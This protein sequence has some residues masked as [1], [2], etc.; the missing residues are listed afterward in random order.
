MLTL[1]VGPVRRVFAWGN[2]PATWKVVQI[3]GLFLMVGGFVRR[4]RA[5]FPLGDYMSVPV[6]ARGL[7]MRELYSRIGNPICVYRA[8]VIA[9]LI[10][11]FAAVL[12]RLAAAFAGSGFCDPYSAAAGVRAEGI[13]GS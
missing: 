2:L 13:S 7:I 12:R 4:A 10:S 8:T 1:I 3:I 5:P 6:R 9:G 11:S